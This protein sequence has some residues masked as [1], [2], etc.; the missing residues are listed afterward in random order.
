MLGRNPVCNAGSPGSPRARASSRHLPRA[1]EHAAST[2][3]AVTANLSPTQGSRRALLAVLLLTGLL[4]IGGILA[5]T[6]VLSATAKTRGALEWEEKSE[7]SHI[8][9]RR[10][11]DLRF[12]CFVRDNGVEACET[13]MNL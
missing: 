7:F 4:A 5:I 2:R 10:N 13:E 12:M 9:I 8:R 3:T 11:G 1:A 6:A